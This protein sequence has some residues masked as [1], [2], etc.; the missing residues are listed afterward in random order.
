MGAKIYDVARL[1]G[2]S[3]GTVS[4]AIHQKGYIRQE[5]RKRVMEAV[6]KLDYQPNAS[7]TRLVS[8]K[9]HILGLLVP[10]LLESYYVEITDAVLECAKQK[11]YHILLTTMRDGSANLPDF[12]RDGNMDGLLVVTPYYLKEELSLVS[13]RRFPCV[14]LN[15][16]P[17]GTHFSAVYCDQFA[18]GYSAIRYL[19]ELGH[20][21]IGFCTSDTNSPSPLKRLQGCLQALR[22]AGLEVT[23]AHVRDM[24]QK[25]RKD[26]VQEIRDWIRSG[27][28]PS[29]M[30]VFSDDIALYLMDALKEAGYRIPHDISILGCGNMLLST[31]TIPPLTTIDQHT[32]EMGTRAVELLLRLMEKPRSSPPV[33]EKIAPRLVIRESCQKRTDTRC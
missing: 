14:M 19:I 17:E 30:F 20:T 18:L 24:S 8:G 1:A 23:S 12:L 29:A 26:P 27:D 15:Y 16:A 10:N 31:R 22:D 5:T 9:T 25:L 11:S 28:L 2:V 6:R 3:P 32:C 4:R 7:A 33:V 21:R 13:R